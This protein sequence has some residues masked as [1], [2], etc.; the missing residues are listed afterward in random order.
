MLELL[1]LSE[2]DLGLRSQQMAEPEASKALSHSIEKILG[3]E[4]QKGRHTGDTREETGSVCQRITA[5]E[6]MI[7]STRG[8]WATK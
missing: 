6:A 8:E 7:K 1:E 4:E 2:E 3:R 5:E